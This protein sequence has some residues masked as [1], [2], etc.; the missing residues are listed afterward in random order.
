MTNNNNH[1]QSKPKYSA[2]YKYKIVKEALTTRQ[3]ISDI[4]K[5]YAIS[6]GTF[7]KWQEQFLVSAKHGFEKK[8]DNG[9][10]ETH[11]LDKLETENT[12]LK[13]VIAEI[14]AE[15]IEFKKKFSD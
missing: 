15:N 3:S 4:C 14:T 1:N 5:K 9:T 8:K 2:E 6:P 7:Y 13:N 11:Q 10:R 12:R